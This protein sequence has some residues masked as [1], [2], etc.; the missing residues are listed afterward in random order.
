MKKKRMVW[1]R[2]FSLCLALLL[3]LSLLPAEVFAADTELK[4]FQING[5]DVTS[6]N[7]GKLDD[8][9]GVTYGTN[10]S[11]SY[12]PDTGTLTLNNVTIERTGS[13]VPI[14]C[15]NPGAAGTI[16]LIGK[17]TLVCSKGSVSSVL[18]V[19]PH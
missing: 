8:S 12:D 15:T 11:I 6:E 5:T 3:C 16:K 17:N 1:R 14:T 10:G 9:N 7:A 13:S 19:S 4:I 18:H 2:G